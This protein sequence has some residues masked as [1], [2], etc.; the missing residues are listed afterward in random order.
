MGPADE[1][2]ST[3]A[4][5]LSGRLARSDVPAMLERIVR[6]LEGTSTATSIAT[7]LPSLTRISSP[8]T[9]WPRSSF[10]RAGSGGRSASS[11]PLRNSV[12]SSRWR[13]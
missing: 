3:I 11:T 13:A 6:L 1:A 12:D 8:W 10:G 7:W 5:V 4:L 2:P 9:H